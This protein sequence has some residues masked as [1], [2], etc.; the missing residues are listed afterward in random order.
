MA[1]APSRKYL[2]DASAARALRRL[3][4]ASTYTAIDI[5][6]MPRKTRIRSRAAASTIMPAA[7]KSTMT[8]PSPSAIPS[9]RLSSIESAMVIA[10]A[11]S[12]S[13]STVQRKPST[14]IMPGPAL[15]PLTAIQIT[16]AAVIAQRISASTPADR[17][18]AADSG[19]QT[20]MSNSAIAPAM[21]IMS[22]VSAAASWPGIDR[23]KDI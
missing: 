10:V 20:T 12:T 16:E 11:S 22:G 9:R 13:K 4:P 23:S 14:A 3:R 5:S 18:R 1:N 21:R 2:R 8:Y 15:A 7:A 17:S 6:S 19:R